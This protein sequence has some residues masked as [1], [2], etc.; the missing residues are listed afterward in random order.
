MQNNKGVF[1]RRWVVSDVAEQL[2]E[3]V[4]QFLSPLWWLGTG[5]FTF[6]GFLILDRL[7]FEAI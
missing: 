7:S 4:F 3:T 6:Y 5:A 2:I 1:K